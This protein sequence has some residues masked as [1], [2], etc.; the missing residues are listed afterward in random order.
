MYNA[1]VCIIFISVRLVDGS[2][3]NEG[4]VEVYYN[5]EWGTV[6]NNKWNENKTKMV[7]MELG[8]GPFGKQDNFGP[9]S[10][11]ILLDSI[12]C[13]E[14]DQTLASCGHYGVGITPF[15]T[16]SQDVGVKCFGM[17]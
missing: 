1:C 7:C 11:R 9:G 8:V 6:C 15:C 12:I 3:Y 10:G 5:G 17:T 4:R 14:N 16:H 2:S 13:F